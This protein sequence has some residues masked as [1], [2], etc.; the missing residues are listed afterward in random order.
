M[1]ETGREEK[2]WGLNESHEIQL[3]IS[4][5]IP[6]RGVV[7]VGEYNVSREM[8]AELGCLL[9]GFGRRV[10]EHSLLV[11][12]R[13]VD[14]LEDF[15]LPGFSTERK[16]EYI[17]ILPA[18]SLLKLKSVTKESKRRKERRR[19]PGHAKF[20]STHFAIR[21]KPQTSLHHSQGLE[22]HLCQATAEQ[23]KPE[24]KHSF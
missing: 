14:I 22:L 2:I 9:P 15:W 24:G 20:Q 6:K 23:K 21:T 5:N 8:R 19:K 1:L 16:V 11:K 13:H 12:D 3:M 10:S 7:P 17:V 18:L 4:L